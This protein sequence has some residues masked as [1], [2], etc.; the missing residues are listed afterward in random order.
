MLSEEFLIKLCIYVT[1]I[2]FVSIVSCITL[3]DI[4]KNRIIIL[5][6]LFWVL[7]KD[8][9][10]KKQQNILQTSDDKYFATKVSNLFH[11]LKI[12]TTVHN[13]NTR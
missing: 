10:T 13:K 3:V 1:D 5:N 12:Y 4:F 7:F 11:K 9:T 8:N 2:T 6:H